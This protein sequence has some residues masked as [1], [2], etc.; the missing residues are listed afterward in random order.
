MDLK[1]Y[2]TC[3]LRQ[4]EY[5][6]WRC[7]WS[8]GRGG[9]RCSCASSQTWQKR[10]S[11]QPISHVDA[12]YNA[13]E[14]QQTCCTSWR[15]AGNPSWWQRSCSSSAWPQHQWGYVHGWTPNN[16]TVSLPSSLKLTLLPSVIFAFYF[17]PNTIHLSSEGTL[18]VDVVSYTGLSWSLEAESRVA[19]EP[20]GKYCNMF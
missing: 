15:S 13:L 9:Q 2:S 8:R 10:I 19:H 12:I 18:L 11:Q 3:I 14:L 1:S 20:G 16:K 17:C 5:H 4:W 6:Q 7:L